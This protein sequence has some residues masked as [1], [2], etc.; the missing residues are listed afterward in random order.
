MQRNKFKRCLF[1]PHGAAVRDQPAFE[2]ISKIAAENVLFSIHQVCASEAA[3]KASSS[4]P[5][6]F[7]N[8]PFSWSAKES[9]RLDDSPADPN[10]NFALFERETEESGPS[11]ALYYNLLENPERYTGYS[12]GDANRIWHAIYLENCHYINEPIGSNFSSAP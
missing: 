10:V 1:A 8:F 3:C 6:I 7:G 11:G 4:S 5:A 2:A 12:G 9:S